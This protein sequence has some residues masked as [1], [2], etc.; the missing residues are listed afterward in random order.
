V[1]ILS[2]VVEAIEFRADD[3]QGFGKEAVE[4]EDEIW[5]R[6]TDLLNGIGL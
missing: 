1:R 4:K 3:G 6:S 2:I 5:Q